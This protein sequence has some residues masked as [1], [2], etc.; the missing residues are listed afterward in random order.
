MSPVL[1]MFL[2]LPQRGPGRILRSGAS[3]VG[4]SGVGTSGLGESVIKDDESGSQ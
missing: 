4:T 3:G 1:R 2:G